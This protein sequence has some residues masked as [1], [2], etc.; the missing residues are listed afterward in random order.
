MKAVGV[1]CL[2]LGYTTTLFTFSC[3]DW[4]DE[5]RTIS[6]VFQPATVSA[7]QYT[8]SYFS[9]SDEER[10]LAGYSTYLPSGDPDNGHNVTIRGYVTDVDAGS[11]YYD[12]VVTVTRYN[13]F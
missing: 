3:T 9:A 2:S 7:L 11:T 1:F 10:P 8:F 12:F 4:Q 13:K 5:R 6:E